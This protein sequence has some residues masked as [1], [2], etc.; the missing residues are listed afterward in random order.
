MGRN[1]CFEKEGLNRG[2]WTPIEDQILMDYINAH[3]DGNWKE[4]PSRAGL[5]RCGKSCRLRWL[6]YLRP[7]IKRGNITRDEEDL[8]LRLHK[9]LGNRGR[10]SKNRPTVPP[11]MELKAVRT[12]ATRCT[13]VFFDP[14]SPSLMG[15]ASATTSCGPPQP[16]RAAA[17]D[18]KISVIGENSLDFAAMD[19]GGIA[20]LS[21]SDLLDYSDLSNI[22]EF[23]NEVSS[24]ADFSQWLEQPLA[25]SDEM[26]EDWSKFSSPA[27]DLP[28]VD[29][30]F[31]H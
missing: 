26:V 18:D 30:W 3:G 2:A 20:D 7:D 27:L 25:F 15:H 28:V 6:N 31:A 19:L 23:G 12:K 29:H 8:I 22:L 24:D 4:L 5:R 17:A 16:T 14:L 13:K 11:A 9:L 1:P 10:K 21:L